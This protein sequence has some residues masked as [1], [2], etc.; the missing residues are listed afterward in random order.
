MQFFE[1]FAAV[2]AKI[3][4]G[5]AVELNSEMIDEHRCRK[6]LHLLALRGPTYRKL[7]LRTATG[8]DRRRVFIANPPGGTDILVGSSEAQK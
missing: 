3:P 1:E 8:A 6:Y 2:A 4:E 5:G 7:V